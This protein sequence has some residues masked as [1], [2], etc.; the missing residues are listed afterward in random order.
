MARAVGDLMLGTVALAA[1]Y[2]GIAKAS[3]VRSKLAEIIQVA[4]LGY[5]AG[6]TA[7]DA[8]TTQYDTESRKAMVRK[9]AGI[10]ERDA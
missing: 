9:L 2:N 7:S 10:P 1:E 8:I 3:H 5:A 4:E 6:Y